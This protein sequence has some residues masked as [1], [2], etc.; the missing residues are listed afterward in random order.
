K[1]LQAGT[2]H[3]LGQNFSR[4]SD[5]QFQDENGEQQYVWTTSWGVST[6]LIGALI[7]THSDD[8]GLVLPPRLA[9]KHVVVLPIWRSDEDRARVLERCEALA[10]ELA[11]QRFAGEPIRVVVDRSEAHGGR[12]WEYIKRGVPIRLE[13][14]P[15]DLE[16][17]SVCLRRRDQ[18]PRDKAFPPQ[19]ELVARAPDILQEIQDELYRRALAFREQHTR[20]IDSLDELRAFFTPQNE[21]RPEIHGGF[22]LVHRADDPRVHELLKELKVTIRC[23]PLDGEEEPGRCVVTGE[24]SARRALLAKAY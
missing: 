8:D 4:V 6:R 14:G 19:G 12:N 5:I 20:R 15:R 21:E 2:S 13:I 11:D 23:I 24:P 10:G 18:A 1:A 7:M 16:K 22:A 17:G 9:P 3:F